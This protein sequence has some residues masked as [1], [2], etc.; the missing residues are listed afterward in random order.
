MCLFSSPSALIVLALV[1]PPLGLLLVRWHPRREQQASDRH[2]ASGQ[3]AGSRRA[4]KLLDCDAAAAAGGESRDPNASEGPRRRP[5]LGKKGVAIRDMVATQAL[6]F[7]NHG[8]MYYDIDGPR[9]RCT[10]KHTVSSSPTLVVWFPGRRQSGKGRNEGEDSVSAKCEKA[11][12]PRASAKMQASLSRIMSAVVDG[13]EVAAWVH[14]EMGYQH[15]A[16]LSLCLMLNSELVLQ[17]FHPSSSY[18]GNRLDM[19][20]RSGGGER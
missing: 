4:S 6:L 1:V 20:C 3:Q 12:A 16:T 13:R 10:V 7:A 8:A 9:T 14:M 17:F 11:S 5:R 15:P 18:S 2:A 19:V